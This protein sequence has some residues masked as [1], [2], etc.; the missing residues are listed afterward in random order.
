MRCVEEPEALAVCVGYR[1]V[2]Q[3]YQF[4]ERMT[5]Q[6]PPPICFSPNTLC[7]YPFPREECFTSA[8]E[9]LSASRAERALRVHLGTCASYRWGPDLPCFLTCLIIQSDNCKNKTCLLS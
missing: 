1:K 2:T 4:K 7:L 3:L 9:D 5:D 6:K 8:Q